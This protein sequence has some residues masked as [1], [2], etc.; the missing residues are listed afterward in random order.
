[1][2]AAAAAPSQSPEEEEAALECVPRTAPKPAPAP[3]IPRPK[4]TPAATVA[5]SGRPTPG[6]APPYGFSAKP[7]KTPF[8]ALRPGADVAEVLAPPPMAPPPDAAF[9]AAARGEGQRPR[10]AAPPA[11]DPRA[12]K[13][14]KKVSAKALQAAAADVAA[15]APAQRGGLD[16]L[17]SYTP[18]GAPAPG[19]ITIRVLGPRALEEETCVVNSTAALRELFEAHATRK[20]VAG[21][22][23]RFSVANLS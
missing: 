5:L 15:P 18:P 22:A 11:A 21:F 23:L 20:G 9:W 4:A 3:P 10:A 14:A 16:G 7:P 6:G 8:A 12:R 13:R 2:T 19:R 17:G 1:M